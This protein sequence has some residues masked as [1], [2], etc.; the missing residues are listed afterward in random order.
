MIQ[1]KSLTQWA[2]SEHLLNAWL[3]VNVIWW[4][5][6]RGGWTDRYPLLVPRAEA[7]TWGAPSPE[8]GG[9]SRS[10][11]DG[12]Q[13]TASRGRGRCSWEAAWDEGLFCV[14]TERRHWM[15]RKLVTHYFWMC[16]R[17]FVEEISIKMDAVDFSGGSVT[18]NRPANSGDTGSISCSG[19]IPHAEEHLSSCA[20]TIELGL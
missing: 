17:V 16:V 13:D 2:F 6:D 9:S 5:G 18:K 12:G 14:S 11:G 19:R 15:P 4:L 20:T 10:W 8:G 7:V 3:W 1:G